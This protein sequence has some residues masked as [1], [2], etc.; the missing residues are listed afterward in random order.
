MPEDEFL[1]MANA[2]PLRKE[3]LLNFGR[4]GFPEKAYGE[5]IDRLAR[6]L[7]RIQAEIANSGGPW[8]LGDTLTIADIAMMPVIVRLD[9]LSLHHMWDDKPEISRWLE[10]IQ[11][12]PA[13]AP[14]FYHGSLLT[15]Q[16]AHLRA[17]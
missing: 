6:S 2:K 3:F 1:A 9:D 8:L 13:Y 7:V 4:V 12:H 16:Y 10:A 17:Q 11:A 14:T 5:A 15:E